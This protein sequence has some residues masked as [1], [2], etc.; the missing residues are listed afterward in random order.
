MTK[1]IACVFWAV[2]LADRD[3]TSI[4][5]ITIFRLRYGKHHCCLVKGK[6]TLCNKKKRTKK[7]L[8]VMI[9]LSYDHLSVNM[10]YTRDPIR[11]G[12]LSAW[13]FVQDKGANYCFYSLILQS[14]LLHSN[15]DLSV[16]A[17]YGWYLVSKISQ[18]YEV[19]MIYHN[20]SYSCMMFFHRDKLLYSTLEINNYCSYEWKMAWP[21]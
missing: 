9:Y 17:W 6:C 13:L 7:I 10:L 21:Y 3:K 5:K 8:D 11:D 15:K 19:Y 12:C 4:F 18:D 16:V 2:T 20:W 14:C 1:I